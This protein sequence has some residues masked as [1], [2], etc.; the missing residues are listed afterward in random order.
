MCFIPEGDYR[1]FLLEKL[2]AK[3]GK[4][5]N[6]DGALIGY[7]QGTWNYTLGQKKDIGQMVEP[8][9]CVT[10]IDAKTIN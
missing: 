2:L 6:T 4:I 5:T 7:H 8:D 9:F 1:K 3:R 10:E